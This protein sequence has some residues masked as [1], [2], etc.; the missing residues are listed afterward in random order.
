MLNRVVPVMT[1]AIEKVS[2]KDSVEAKFETSESK[3]VDF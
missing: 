3:R 2:K 1:D